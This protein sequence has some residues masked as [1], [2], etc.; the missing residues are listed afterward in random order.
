MSD[1]DDI[2]ALER[3]LRIGDQLAA[4]LHPCISGHKGDP[5]TVPVWQWWRWSKQYRTL[6]NLE[7]ETS[8]GLD[9][10]AP[11]PGA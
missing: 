5:A 6:Y 4:L 1:P 7:A 3:L 10:V 9:P 11:N 8:N 2:K